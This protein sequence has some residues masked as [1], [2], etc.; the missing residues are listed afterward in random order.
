MSTVSVDYLQQ[1]VAARV[2]GIIR[3]SDQQAAID[4]ALTLFDEGL[5]QV[6][7]T[8][9]TP[10]ALAAIERIRGRAP[11]GALTGAGTVVSA[12]DAD[13]ASAAGAQFL[14]TPAVVPSIEA[15]AVRGLPVLAGAMTPTEA[16]T[17]MERGATAVKLFPASSLGPSHLTAVRDPF[18]RIPFVA[19]GG[20]GL[21]DVQAYLHA[22]AVAVGVGAP[23]VGDA[24]SG[25]DLGALRKRARAYRAL[26]DGLAP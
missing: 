10:G 18:P 4:T 1:L 5:R 12:Q 3:G 6:E 9:T 7:V 24:A 8:L 15:G 13:D 19:V 20:V 2:V 23:L 26:V 21:E 16:W 25:G 17:A 11:E 22:G 14:V